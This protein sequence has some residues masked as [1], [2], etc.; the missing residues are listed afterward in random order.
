MTVRQSTIKEFLLSFS[1]TNFLIINLF[2][3]VLVYVYVYVWS[4]YF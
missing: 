3:F 2:K 4:F 1:F